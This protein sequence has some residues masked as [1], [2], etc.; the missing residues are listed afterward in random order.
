MLCKKSFFFKKDR[1]KTLP[2][3]GGPS[4]SFPILTSP[5]PVGQRTRNGWDIVHLH[6][7][8]SRHE[9]VKSKVQAGRRSSKLPFW[10]F[11]NPDLFPDF[12]PAIFLQNAISD[13]RTL[14]KKMSKYLLLGRD[15]GSNFSSHLPTV[16]LNNF[17]TLLLYMNLVANLI[18]HMG[19]LPLHQLCSCLSF[20][21]CRI[22]L[23]MYLIV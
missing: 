9:S 16:L 22:Y 4:P 21:V 10:C 18:I 5:S 20:A 1:T 7:I 14:Q 17:S 11:S 19:L 12:S 2:V 8:A 13:C 15:Y 6:D 23:M 3:H